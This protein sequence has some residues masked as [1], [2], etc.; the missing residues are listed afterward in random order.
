MAPLL[1]AFFVFT[2]LS[3]VHGGDE[4]SL[5]WEI[6]ADRM[7]RQ[8]EPE[9]IT[10]EGN[11]V[12]KQYQEGS[13]TGLAVEAETVQYNVGTNSVRAFGSVHLHGDIRRRGV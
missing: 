4:E 5:P 3:P 10:A 13:P 8:K 12:L 9:Q 1:A 6:T 2:P 7:T 11:V